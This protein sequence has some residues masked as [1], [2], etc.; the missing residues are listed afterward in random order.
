MPQPY[1]FQTFL[2][3][4]IDCTLSYSANLRIK[5]NLSLDLEPSE[6]RYMFNWRQ[7]VKENVMLRTPSDLSTSPAVAGGIPHRTWQVVLFPDPLA[8]KIAISSPY[9][10]TKDESLTATQLSL[11]VFLRCATRSPA[12][13][14]RSRAVFFRAETSTSVLI[15]PMSDE[16][17]DT[18]EGRFLNHRETDVLEGFDVAECFFWT[19]LNQLGRSG[20]C[21][22]RAPIR[23]YLAW[24]KKNG[25][26]R[27]PY[28]SGSTES[29]Y[30]T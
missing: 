4:P 6:M 10:I 24:Q 19:L 21:G 13:V 25:D 23:Q 15:A 22:L 17:V 5:T 3:H 12:G 11:N 1:S 8:P 29:R 26:S 16:R 27:T 7:I 28:S 30:L 18:A 14:E 2:G 20:F 9:C